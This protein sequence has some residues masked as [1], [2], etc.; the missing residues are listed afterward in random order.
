MGLD[1]DKVRIG[2]AV[3]RCLL[4]SVRL[5]G[6]SIWNGD[7]PTVEFNAGMLRMDRR[8]CRAQDPAIFFKAIS[9]Q[10]TSTPVQHTTRA[11][12]CSDANV[13]TFRECT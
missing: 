13:N 2:I 12:R 4:E 6:V 11:N 9:S 7:F 1:V 3:K 5:R 8:C 10:P